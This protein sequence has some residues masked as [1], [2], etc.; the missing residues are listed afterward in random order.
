MTKVVVGGTYRDY[1]RWRDENHLSPMD[2]LYV[3]E[4]AERLMGLELEP[5]QIV[6][7]G[8]ISKEFE[9]LLLTRIRP[10]RNTR[11]ERG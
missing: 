10:S 6:R 8:I 9:E 11:E 3:G 5:Q 2:A 7:L 1:V 4:H